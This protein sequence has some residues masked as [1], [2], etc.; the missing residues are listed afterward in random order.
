[1]DFD[2]CHCF[3]WAT[4]LHWKVIME[5]QPIIQVRDLTARYGEE[6]ILEGVSFDVFEGEIFVILGGSGCG[7]STLLKHLIALIRPYTG[8]VIVDG[9]DISRGDSQVVERLLRKIGIL[10]QSGALFGSMTLAENIALPIMEYTDL[11]PELVSSLVRMKLN[12]VQLEGYEDYLPSDISGGMKKR[13]G[14]ARA[15]AL[16]PKILFFDEPSAGLDPVTS[17]GL[18]NLILHLN[19]SLGTTMVI[20]THELQSILTVAQRVIML[21][22]GTKGIIAEGDPRHLRETSRNPSVWRFFNR[23][24]EDSAIS[25]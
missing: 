1:L 23:Q 14:L 4:G 13:A 19:K 10:Y 2:I 24:P 15:M 16:N 21:D 12:L 8:Q 3:V 6:T 18:D 17:A 9:D 7:K 11:S 5:R 25:G 22:K 20:V